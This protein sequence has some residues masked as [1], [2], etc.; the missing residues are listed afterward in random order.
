[1]WGSATNNVLEKFQIMQNSATRILTGS[2]YEIPSGDLLRQLN[3]KTLKERRQN[4]KTILMYKVNHG[5]AFEPVNKLFQIANNQDYSLRSNLN[6]FLPDKPNTN[7]VEKSISYAGAQCWNNLPSDL[8]G[9]TVNLKTFR[10]ILE[11][12]NSLPIV[13]SKVVTSYK[14]FNK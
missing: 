8:K 13:F 4:K 6:N 3:W 2:S 11:D 1:M 14:K 9:H 7:F 10:A 5:L 12:Y